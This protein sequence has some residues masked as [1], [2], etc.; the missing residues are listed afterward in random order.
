MAASV[1]AVALAAAGTTLLAT[2][3]MASIGECSSG[4]FCLW[5]NP[6]QDAYLYGNSG[7]ARYVGNSANDRASS[8]YNHGNYC[9]I[10][11]WEH[12]DYGGYYGDL[13]RGNSY[14][15]LGA[16]WIV[17]PSMTWTDRISS[18]YWVC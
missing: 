7:N 12:A 2:P 3:A 10:R 11:Y 8:I 4:S 13:A 5:D 1:G 14:N 17:G 6:D 16:K 15:N 9:D 18:F